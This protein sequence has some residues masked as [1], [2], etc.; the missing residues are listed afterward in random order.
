MCAD[1]LGDYSGSTQCEWDSWGRIAPTTPPQSGVPERPVAGLPRPLAHL[2]SQRG[3]IPSE[4]ANLIICESQPRHVGRRLL[5]HRITQPFLELRLSV[6]APDTGQVVGDRSTGD[7]EPMAAVAALGEKTV[8]PASVASGVDCEDA[9][10]A[11]IRQAATASCSSAC[12]IR[13]RTAPARA[14]SGTDVAS[15]SMNRSRSARS[16]RSTS[17][18]TRPLTCLERSRP[19]SERRQRHG[20]PRSRG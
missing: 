15:L 6:L 4:R 11:N 5:T 19:G 10:V 7:A 14:P 13:L 8:R 20:R 9:D 2:L 16:T 12:S 3:Q 18:M 1:S 17:F